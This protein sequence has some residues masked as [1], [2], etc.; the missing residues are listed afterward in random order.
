MSL[1]G[2][3]PVVP[4]QLDQLLPTGTRVDVFQEIYWVF[5]G[6]GTL[7]GIVVIGYML[8]NA[9][10]YQD[11]GTTDDRTEKD[12]PQLGELP[13]GGGKGRKLFLSFALSA[14][15]VVS[16][17][18]WTYTAVLYVEGGGSAQAQTQAGDIEGIE[19]A[20]DPTTNGDGP[21]YVRVEGFQFGW[22]FIYPNG[23]SNST[24]VIPEDRQVRIM[25]T[26]TD[27]FHNFGIPAFNVKSDA[28]PGETTETWFVAEE[29]GTYEAVCY[30]LCGA[31]HSYMNADVTVVSDGEFQAWYERQEAAQEEEGNETSGDDS[32]TTE[33]GE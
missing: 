30:E 2:A 16:L 14:L 23:A 3:T 18:V 31:G 12:R 33:E 21:V 15:I 28:I 29:T 32:N 8:Y 22:N 25:V 13:E 11:D 17:I 7:V 19:D 1:T 6:L 10:K 26:S 27:V 5:L 20:P 24:L 9:Y 4:L